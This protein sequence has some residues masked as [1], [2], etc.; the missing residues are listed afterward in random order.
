MADEFPSGSHVVSGV[1]T[2]VFE[3]G[4]QARR[5]ARQLVRAADIEHEEC[6]RVRIMCEGSFRNMRDSY[7]MDCRE[8]T[9]RCNRLRDLIEECQEACKAAGHRCTKTPKPAALWHKVEEM[10]GRWR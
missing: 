3:E 4:L 10:R 9:H 1:P 7:L 5:R 6:D 8:Q 2:E